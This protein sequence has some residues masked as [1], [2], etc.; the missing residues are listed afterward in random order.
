[1]T[2]PLNK[3]LPRGSRLESYV[4]HLV[5]ERHG[6]EEHWPWGDPAARAAGLASILREEPRVW[7]LPRYFVR[8]QLILPAIAAVEGEEAAE[9]VQRLIPNVLS[10]FVDLY[11]NEA[12][13]SAKARE[14]LKPVPD[15][16]WAVTGVVLAVLYANYETGKTPNANYERTARQLDIDRAAVRRIDKRI[17]KGAREPG[18]LAAILA[19]IMAFQDCLAE[20]G[21]AVAGRAVR[22]CSTLGTGIAL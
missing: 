7:E 18:V 8:D 20:Y 15:I 17:R 13:R 16:S 9:V 1:M 2:R 19:A 4:N 21:A 5:A 6:W 12:K 10:E 14:R 11:C 22:S 3:E